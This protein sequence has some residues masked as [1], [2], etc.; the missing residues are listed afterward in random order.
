MI[1]PRQQDIQYTRSHQPKVHPASGM[2]DG[3]NDIGAF[4][5]QLLGKA[6]GGLKA[7]LKTQLSGV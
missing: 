4:S 3:D 1:I 6:F 5:P 2:G 7:A